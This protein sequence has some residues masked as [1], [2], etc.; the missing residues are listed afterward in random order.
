MKDL[1]GSIHWNLIGIYTD[2]ITA[3]GHTSTIQDDQCLADVKMAGHIQCPQNQTSDV[4][5]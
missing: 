2:D 1:P 4:P 3:Y 5:S